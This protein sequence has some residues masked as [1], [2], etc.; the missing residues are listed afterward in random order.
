V[1]YRTANQG[2]RWTVLVT[3]APVQRV[4]CGSD[5]V[6]AL[7]ASRAWLVTPRTYGSYE[8]PIYA[9]SNAGLTWRRIDIA[10]PGR[11][12]A[13][14]PTMERA[15]KSRGRCPHSS[16]ALTR[17]R[18]PAATARPVRQTPV[19]KPASSLRKWTRS[20]PGTA[21]SFGSTTGRSIAIW[22]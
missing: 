9:T 7:G 11:R 2:R 13:A 17:P 6:T 8:T 22:R 14:L 1:V 5:Q 21:P 12:V 4:F 15:G 19:A 3:L 10:A 16:A 18:F 20:N